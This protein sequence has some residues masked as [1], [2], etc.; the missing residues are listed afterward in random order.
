M[1]RRDTRELVLRSAKLKWRSLHPRGKSG[2]FHL[3]IRIGSSFK[4]EPPHSTKTVLDMNLDRGCV[5]GLAVSAPNCEFE[6]TGTS[7]A[8]YDGNF[9][10]GRW[11][12]STRKWRRYEDENEAQNTKHSVHILIIIRAESESRTTEHCCQM[13]DRDDRIRCESTASARSV[14]T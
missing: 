3:P 13:R 4:I 10:I 2:E 14:L 7:A 9:V 11:R 6:G 12:L 8:F 1:E 5:D